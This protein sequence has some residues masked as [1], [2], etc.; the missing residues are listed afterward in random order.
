MQ[1]HLK[2]DYS[3]GEGIAIIPVLFVGRL[4]GGGAEPILATKDM[5]IVIFEKLPKSTPINGYI[6]MNMR[7]LVL[8]L[9]ICNASTC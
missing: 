3:R 4:G 7:K 9:H 5:N 1:L 8:I 6:V 2:E